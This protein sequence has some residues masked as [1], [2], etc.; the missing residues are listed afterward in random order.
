[1]DAGNGRCLKKQKDGT[2]ER[3][4][5]MEMRHSNEQENRDEVEV[6]AVQQSEEGKYDKTS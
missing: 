2:R 5:G 6:E 3:R 4:L 1:M